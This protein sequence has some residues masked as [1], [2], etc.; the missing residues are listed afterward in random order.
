MDERIGQTVTVDGT[1]YRIL[2][3]LGKGKG[4]IPTWPRPPAG[5][6]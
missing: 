5:S 4:A 6:R 2:R 3:L 1:D